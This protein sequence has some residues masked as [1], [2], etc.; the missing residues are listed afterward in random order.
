MS[1]LTHV[2]ATIGVLGCA[3]IPF[4]T[5]RSLS[6]AS[7][8]AELG[9]SVW[10]GVYTDEQASRGEST[11]LA[12]SCGTCHGEML[13]G[14]EFGS[15]LVGNEFVEIWSQRTVGDLF[16]LIGQTMP[17][18]NPGILTS[19]QTADLVALVLRRNNFPS[20]MEALGRDSSALQGIKILQESAP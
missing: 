2:L 16:D 10:D 11:Y 20:G 17:S 8:Q 6:S 12:E 5:P 18:N 15:P 9:S 19:R 14:A 3:T 13:R 1:R 4:V 7:A